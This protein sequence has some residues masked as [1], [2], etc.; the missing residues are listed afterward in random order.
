MVRGDLCEFD[1]AGRKIACFC[2][3]HGDLPIA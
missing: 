2:Y 1:G 3:R